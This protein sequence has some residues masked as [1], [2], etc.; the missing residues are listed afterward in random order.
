MVNILLILLGCNI[1]DILLN[2]IEVAGQ[3]LQN[4]INIK[5]TQ[6]DW[7]LSGGIK[8]AHPNAESEA[9]IMQRL[10]KTKLANVYGQDQCQSHYQSHYQSQYQSQYQSHYQNNYKYKNYEENICQGLSNW[11][12]ILDTKSTNTAQNFVRA[13]LYYNQTSY[14]YSD[15]Y[16]IT[17]AFHKERANKLMNY[18]DPTNQF[19]WIL[20]LTELAD[21]RHMEQIHIKNVYSDYIGAIQSIKD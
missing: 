12:F 15:V 17:S 11:N 4:S 9:I 16:I 6:I 14:K 21:S 13:S 18:I 7:F 19:K 3:F 5:N 20:G 2:R 10:I 1:K 8:F